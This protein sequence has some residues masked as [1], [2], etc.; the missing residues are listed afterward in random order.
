MQ[1]PKFE[2]LLR[3]IELTSRSDSL[4]SEIED[5]LLKI[6]SFNNFFDLII[7]I[8]NYPEISMAQQN[9]ALLLLESEIKRELKMNCFLYSTNVLKSNVFKLLRKNIQNRSLCKIIQSIIFN[10]VIRDYPVNW[11]D[12]LNIVNELLNPNNDV[13]EI[14]TGLRVL[15][16]VVNV[17]KLS[18]N[19]ERQPIIHLINYTF[20]L[21]GNLV[22]MFSKNINSNYYKCL[23]LIFKLFINANYF[24]LDKFFT[25]QIIKY[26]LFA[27]LKVIEDKEGQLKYSVAHDWNEMI[28]LENTIEHKLQE[29][30]FIL[31]KNSFRLIIK[32][33]EGNDEWVSLKDVLSSLLNYSL[34]YIQNYLMTL[35][36]ISNDKNII[37]LSS[38]NNS[39]I[40]AIS[41]VAQAF[42]FNY[43]IQEYMS[44]DIIEDII[45]ELL[46]Y[47]VQ[48]SNFEMELFHEDQ[49][50]YLFSIHSSCDPTMI[51]KK[52]A[53]EV[54]QIIFKYE[55]ILDQKILNFIFNSIQFLKNSRTGKCLD[56]QFVEGLIYLIESIWDNIYKKL[57][58]IHSQLLENIFLPILSSDCTSLI[59]KSRTCSII[60]TISNFD[61]CTIPILTETCKYVCY[62]F[63]VEN[64][65]YLTINSLKALGSLSSNLVVP[66][67]LLNSLPD[68]LHKT[69]F[70]IKEGLIE[71][72]LYYLKNLISSFES[73]IIPFAKDLLDNLFDGFWN[74]IQSNEEIICDQNEE[75]NEKGEV[76]DSIEITFQTITEIISLNLPSEL[77]YQIGD[78]I[79]SSFLYM[80]GNIN[81]RMILESA[82]TMLNAYIYRIPNINNELWSFFPVIC[83]GLLGRPKTPI[84]V[85]S[86]NLPEF[87]TRLFLQTDLTSLLIQE[88]VCSLDI[89]I[90]LLINFVQKDP[91]FFFGVVDIYGQRVLTYIFSIADQLITCGAQDDIDLDLILAIRLISLFPENCMKQLRENLFIYDDILK[92]FN[93]FMNL[94]NRKRAKNLIV[95]K[96]CLLMFID[97]DLFYDELEKTRLDEGLKIKWFSNIE[98]L[99][100]VEEKEILLLGIAGLFKLSYEKLQNFNISFL[101]DE[102]LKACK[103]MYD[104]EQKDSRKQ[105][106]SDISV[107]FENI[108]SGNEDSE[109]SSWNE[110]VYLEERSL[111]FSDP[112][113][114]YNGVI[115]LQKS[116]QLIEHNNPE[117]F[118]MI[119]S[120]MNT[121]QQTE[122]LEYFNFFGQKL[123]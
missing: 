42:Q 106:K 86:S 54:F 122:I 115:E 32:L 1:N 77:L 18:L 16:T 53:I 80:L 94:E 43:V 28:I 8:V 103:E 52:S 105:N 6:R 58:N 97:S 71:D 65:L 30:A 63:S 2:I 34:T 104:E 50:R 79:K 93:G 108:D 91:S 57:K 24:S 123:K 118:A 3:A 83:Y 114:S 107:E 29:K 5:I 75:T 7:E 4:K 119:I 73:E 101:I 113:E 49:Y 70:L 33:A 88:L 100:S 68:I 87:Q 19:E 15:S 27:A 74:L 38:T 67:I 22:I 46:I 25:P 110:E 9:I 111:E 55:N 76:V 48:I 39:A 14:E 23:F 72:S 10:L 96:I 35:N 82:V 84:K 47:C 26:W 66:S 11:P 51:F 61:D 121:K 109:D 13:L 85:D 45:Y 21:V 95:Q 112:F 44:E 60:A 90:A 78:H 102:A 31:M 98:L 36:L 56:D 120:Q 92:Y 89:I 20:P 64:N 17:Y 62:C 41:L 116:W 40:A 81:L 59:L 99:T 12:L 69:S 37:L 117:L